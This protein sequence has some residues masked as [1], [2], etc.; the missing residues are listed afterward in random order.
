MVFGKKE[1]YSDE[2]IVKGLDVGEL[3][4]Y[5]WK[6]HRVHRGG[7]LRDYRT[8]N[9]AITDKRAIITDKKGNII[10]SCPINRITILTSVYD[11]DNIGDIEF[12]K[13]NSCLLRFMEIRDPVAEKQRLI[14]MGIISQEPT[15]DSMQEHES[16]ISPFTKKTLPKGHDM[17][18]ATL[19]TSTQTN[20]Q[21]SED[22]LKIL[23]LRFAKGEITKEEFEETKNY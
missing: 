14:M 21:P 9:Y 2:D 6:S 16:Q 18:G 11:R 13:G 15:R 22:P 4:K 10:E 8:Y 19:P 7:G 17:H 23:K 12:W 20:F 5:Y 3:I 1:K